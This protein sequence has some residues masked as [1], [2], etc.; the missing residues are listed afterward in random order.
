VSIKRK[1]KGP[2]PRL[3]SSVVWEQLALDGQTAQART[4]LMRTD[5][6][7]TM[8]QA[9]RKILDFLQTRGV[10]PT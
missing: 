9:H 1:Q 2:A 4:A 7:L 5:S 3:L 10:T 8:T 6:S